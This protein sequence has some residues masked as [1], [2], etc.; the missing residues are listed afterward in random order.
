VRNRQG[1]GWCG[2]ALWKAAPKNT[3]IGVPTS[4]VPAK[5][6]LLEEAAAQKAVFAYEGADLKKGCN[7]KTVVWWWVVY[8][9]TEHRRACASWVNMFPR[10][11]LVC[12][13][14]GAAALATF[15]T[16]DPLV[17]HSTFRPKRASEFHPGLVKLLGSD[18]REIL[19]LTGQRLALRAHEE[20]GVR[21][22]RVRA[23]DLNDQ[24]LTQLLKASSVTVRE[25]ALRT[26]GERDM[27]RL[28]R[29]ELVAVATNTHE[30]LFVRGLAVRVL[31]REAIDS[32]TAE[33]M[34]EILGKSEDI[35][36]RRIVLETL[37]S[38]AGA[39]PSL[40]ER[41]VGFLKAPEAAIQFEAFTT[42]RRVDGARN[43]AAMPA[44]YEKAS[45]LS[46][47]IGQNAAE[48][49]RTGLGLLKAPNLPAYVR[50]TALRSLAYQTNQPGAVQALL[51][52]AGDEDSFIT[53]LAGNVL[54][55][56]PPVDAQGVAALCDGIRSSNDVVRLHA[57]LR[58]SAAGQKLDAISDAVVIE[59]QRIAREGA[60]ARETGL[61]LEIARKLGAEIA[62]AAG[63]LVGMLSESSPAFRDLSKHEV[64]RIRGMT[65]ATMAAMG[66][67]PEALE[68]I[69][70]A[71]ANSDE[72]SVHEFSGAARAA[73][74]L[75]ARGRVTIPHLL[76][77]LDSRETGW[78]GWIALETFDAHTST[79][80]VYTT[81]Q[82][83]ALRALAVLGA[84]DPAVIH[85]LRA[86]VKSAPADSEGIDAGVGIPNAREEAM[87][88]LSNTRGTRGLLGQKATPRGNRE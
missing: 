28:P 4:R 48:A 85:A 25:W 43:A 47:L 67:P 69:V 72:S 30:R 42:L 73:A 10:A 16:S 33:T 86:F 41:L 37:A 21:N 11:G 15:A 63:S 3:R 29:A 75:G 26:M 65:F 1:S 49:A 45:R 35:Q 70:S 19:S 22:E 13:V 57:L 83:E 6:C 23:L 14:F 71:L 9:L 44:D 54:N 84:N 53:E 80:A 38:S 66:T 39:S 20:V 87:K 46:D 61:C 50:C 78:S 64:D 7:R 32:T 88:A 74:R 36:F 59:L 76:R 58:L 31:G 5:A 77:A 68:V 82:V 55:S 18:V 52:A 24:Q 62:P 60:S 81:P 12:L 2:F 79:N 27:E 56:L 40:V 17:P 8:P 34:L 51:T